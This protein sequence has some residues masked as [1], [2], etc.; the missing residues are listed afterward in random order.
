M[1]SEKFSIIS[2]I[3]GASIPVQIVIG[4][5][6]LVSIFSWAIIL[7]KSYKLKLVTNSTNKFE[8]EFWSGG[9][10]MQLM[11]KIESKKLKGSLPRIFE[12]GMHEFLKSRKQ[13]TLEANTIIDNTRRA[14]KSA[15]YKELSQLESRL[16]FLATTGSVSPY[17]GLFGTVWGIMQSFLALANVQ[18]ATLANVA[19]G[20]AEALIATAVGLLA[21]I[22]A[23]I[24]FNK[25]AT[26]VDNL[27]NRFDSF[28]EEFSNILQ[29]QI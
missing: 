14:L 19:P 26:D 11:S 15:S 22:P 25:F 17:I 12:S 3:I 21:A 13:K 23:V 5:L 29:R 20:I 16:P 24:A 6:L 4:I 27:A 7:T 18:Q 2:L 28:T 8:E 10:L 1:I 9:E